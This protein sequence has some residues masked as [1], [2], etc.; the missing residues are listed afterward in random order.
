M[1][2]RYVVILALGALLGVA[3]VVIARW[4]TGPGV[5]SWSSLWLSAALT[6]VGFGLMLAALI[7]GLGTGRD[8]RT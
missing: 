3:A 7:G 8:D 5:Y 6:V 2:T 1:R 4:E